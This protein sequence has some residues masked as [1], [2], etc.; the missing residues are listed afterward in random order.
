M[1]IELS[2]DQRNAVKRMQNGIGL[3]LYSVRG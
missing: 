2:E 3:L 1:D